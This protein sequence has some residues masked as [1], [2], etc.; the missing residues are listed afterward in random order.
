MLTDHKLHAA[1]V[2]VG[3][4]FRVIRFRDALNAPPSPAA[5]ASALREDSL[6][7]GRSRI[8]T[9][10]NHEAVEQAADW[11]AFLSAVSVPDTHVAQYAKVRCG[12]RVWC[13][14]WCAV[15]CAVW[16]AVW[17][18]VRCGA[19]CGVRC[20]ACVRCASG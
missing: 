13:A 17:C 4:A 16:C 10:V 3:H 14:V 1:G 6:T 11:E 15:R 7:S 8:D 5:V 2:K 18:A 9:G 20:G 19:V 12:V